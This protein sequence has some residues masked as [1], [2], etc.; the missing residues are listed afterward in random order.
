M[1][2]QGPPGPAELGP[3]VAGKD[4]QRVLRDAQR[5]HR[6]DELAHAVVHLDHGVGKVAHPAAAGKV[7]VRQGGKVQV[8]QRH[9]QEERL[10][11][12][13]MLLHEADGAFGQL[14]VDQPALGQVVR[15]SLQAGWPA[16]P[17]ITCG[18]STTVGSKPGEL[19]NMVSLL[20]RGMP[21]QVSKP[22][23]CG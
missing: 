13:R 15:V 3:V 9:V 19:V 17:D 6:V 22:R 1:P 21:Y 14:G 2:V 7:G 8:R 16:W 18:T 23:W 10:R 5:V 4:E 20:V 11:P 12:A